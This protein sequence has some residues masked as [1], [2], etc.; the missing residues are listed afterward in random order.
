DVAAAAIKKVRAVAAGEL[1]VLLQDPGLLL[2]RRREVVDEHHHHPVGIAHRAPDL[3]LEHPRREVSAQ[4]VQERAV[5][6]GPPDLARRPP[7]PPARPGQDLLDQVHDAGAGS[8]TSS[9]GAAI[10]P[11]TAVGAASGGPPREMS[12]SE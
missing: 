1:A 12:G 2:G 3:L 4:V 10:A 6:V 7:T 9:R 11:R 5:D 8:E